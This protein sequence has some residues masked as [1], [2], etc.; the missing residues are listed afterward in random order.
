MF[1]LDIT[2]LS[3]QATYE[4]DAYWFLR[5]WNSRH[6]CERCGS[7]NTVSL[8]RLAGASSRLHTHTADSRWQ[9]W[10]SW[11]I[12]KYPRHARGGICSNYRRY[13]VV[14]LTNSSLSE[15]LR[16]LLALHTLIEVPKAT[17]ELEDTPKP[18]DTESA[19]DK[20]SSFYFISTKHI[21]QS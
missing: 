13:V 3:K 21:L 16:V 17:T 14:P 8:L 19:H 15:F 11:P 1:H 7:H 10:Y 4:N 2:L 5:C 6:P 9:V 18:L 20:L 12:L